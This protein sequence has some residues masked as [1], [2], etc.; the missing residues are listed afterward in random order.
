[1]SPRVPGSW[2]AF[3]DDCQGGRVAIGT[4][5]GGA[6]TIESTPAVEGVALQSAAI[7]VILPQQRTATP[8]P[9]EREVDLGP[10]AQDL[11]P[12]EID[13]GRIMD[14]VSL[15]LLLS[16]GLGL[17]LVNALL[18]LRVL[19]IC[20]LGAATLA[21]MWG[22]SL[23]RSRLTLSVLDDLP[24]ISIGVLSS[25]GLM[26][27]LLASATG[28]DA[29]LVIRGGLTAL[30]LLLAG[31]I[32]TYAGIRWAR[33]RGV[34]SY[35]TVIVGTGPTAAK[36]G[37]ILDEHPETGLR[38]VGFLGPSPH[39]DPSVSARILD[40]DCRNL[41]QVTVNQSASVILATVSGVE[42]DDVLVGIRSRDQ[43]RHCTLF[44][45]PAL[46]EVLHAPGTERIQHVPLIRVRPSV[47][48]VLPL[49]VKRLCD[50][51]VAAV[52]LVVAAPLM[53]A[54]ALAVRLEG[55]KGVL[56][57]QERV[58][59]DGELFTL[60]KFRSL[61]PETEDE[62]AQ[63]WSVAAESRLGLVGRFIRRTSLDELPQ[64]VNVLHGDM[65]IIGPRP[66]RPYFVDEFGR[67]YE[68]YALRH[69]VRP[70]LTGWAAVNG[71]RGDTS[72]E[73]RVYFDN[74]YID[75]WSLWLDVKIMFR[76]VWAVVAF[77]GA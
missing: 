19:E 22:N 16:D 8:P 20:L 64:L 68:C 61:R 35:R 76:T 43:K 57:R 74:A 4:S 42:A 46:F 34:V 12:A 33:R 1:M 53:A 60:L 51:V 6:M 49:R 9:A 18:P 37:R 77:R 54:V 28:R 65:S 2:L 72:I 17:L 24:T 71:L 58:G 67:R 69:R 40:E 29:S 3:R 10:A 59:M 38:L 27:V 7:E 75:N 23:Y 31:R 11:S 70:G 14:R 63:R 44:V 41:P 39:A 55:G 50:F 66:E 73:D 56:F 36:V 21:V 52:G 30:L 13:T 25:T 26:A 5:E 32:V 47:L 15:A 45:V 62:S 48:A